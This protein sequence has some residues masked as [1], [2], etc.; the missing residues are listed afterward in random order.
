MPWLNEYMK[1]MVEAVLE[2]DGTI[3]KFI[4]DAVMA[5]FGV[6]IPS[7]EP[8]EIAANAMAAVKCA[9]AMGVKLQSLNK[10]WRQRGLPAIAMRVGIATGSVMA[11]TLGSDRRLD[12]TI[13]GD[14]VN[15]AARL[16]SF[17]Q[18]PRWRNLPDFD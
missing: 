18:V 17:R 6:P 11:G 16:E 15:V 14:T 9:V 1:V 10:Q 7:T 2:H 4:G 8:E 3:D 5:V 13:I 12:Y